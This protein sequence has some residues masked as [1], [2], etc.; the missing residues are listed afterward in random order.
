MIVVSSQ[1]ELLLLITEG[2]ATAEAAELALDRLDEEKIILLVWFDGVADASS[3]ILLISDGWIL[4]LPC[5][6]KT[7]LLE[8]KA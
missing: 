1:G 4:I 2:D 3:I 6:L 5:N 8:D 7:I